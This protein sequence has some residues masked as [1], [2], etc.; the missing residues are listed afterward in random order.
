[1]ATAY[2]RV[3]KKVKPVNTDQSDDSIP[4][5]ILNWKAKVMKKE[6]GL[7]KNDKF[8][9]YLIPKFFTI[10]RGSKLI[11]ERLKTLI[12]GNGLLPKER[13]LFEKMLFCR[14]AVLT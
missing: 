1:M 11:P 6:K 5:G 14:E 10:P 7:S 4:E 12:I 9:D 3:A 2:K 13:E 8:P